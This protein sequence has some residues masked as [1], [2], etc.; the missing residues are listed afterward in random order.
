MFSE[1][2]IIVN[3]FAQDKLSFD[4]V[5][6][7][8]DTK[9]SE[10]QRDILSWTRIYLEQSHPDKTLID[11]GLSLVPLKPTMTPIVLLKT[12][13][14]KTALLKI[15]ALPDNELKKGFITIITLFKLSDTKRREH[16]CKD[17][18]THDWHNL[19]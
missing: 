8:F 10:E 2:D 3:K 14:F 7:W 11:A 13:P 6:H 16:W 9:T 5:M 1:K 15:N 12:Q 4:E 19:D 18:C 17:G